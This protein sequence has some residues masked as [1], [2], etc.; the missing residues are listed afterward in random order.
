M[1]IQHMITLLQDETIKEIPGDIYILN[2][3]LQKF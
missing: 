2:H 3:C 1:H